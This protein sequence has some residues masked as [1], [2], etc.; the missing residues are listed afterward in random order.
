MPVEAM[1]KCS[2]LHDH[3]GV[4]TVG[5]KNCKR[6]PVVAGDSKVKQ[7]TT[8]KQYS[9]SIRVDLTA[10]VS[11]HMAAVVILAKTGFVY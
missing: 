11:T 7:T 4:F 2:I 6:R 8:Q 9:F 3:S 1:V 10:L 5:G